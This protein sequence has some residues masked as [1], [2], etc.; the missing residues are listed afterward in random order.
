[1]NKILFVCAME[2][3]GRQIAEK[4]GMKDIS[5]NEY[6]NEI[7]LFE[8]KDG[9]RRLLISLIG[10]QFTIMNLTKYLCFNEKP[11]LIINIG[12]AGSTDIEIGKWVNISRVYN[13]EWD[14]P[15]EEKY[16]MINGGSQKLM[17]LENS[18]LE[19]VEC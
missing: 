2:K 4:L 13:Y 1:M 5:N 15:G 6:K 16:V 10:K 7:K 8:N 3:E 18:G 14:I 9:N 11:D 17:T 12:Y 19:A